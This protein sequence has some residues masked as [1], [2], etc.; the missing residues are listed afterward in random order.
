MLTLAQHRKRFAVLES[1]ASSWVQHWREIALAVRPRGARF[2]S[3]DAQNAGQ[4][5]HSH[6]VNNTPIISS[7]TLAGGLHSGITSAARP[8][9]RIAV[10]DPMLNAAA[11]V[12]HWLDEVEQEIRDALERSNFYNCLHTGYC[13]LSDFG[14]TCLIE[15]EDE[16]DSVRFY[17]A[18]IGSYFL[19]QSHRLAA[20]TL[21]R[22][23]NLTVLQ[24]VNKFCRAPSGEV[25]TSPLTASTRT[26]WESKR[27]DDV[28]EC[29]HVIAPAEDA[30]EQRASQGRP[31]LSWW[32]E[33]Q[34]SKEWT[35]TATEDGKFLRQSG[36]EERPHFMPRWET[37]GEDVYGTS[38][39]MVALGDCNALQVLEKRKAQLVELSARPPMAGPAGL[40]N[41]PISLVPGGFTPVPTGDA[42][43]AFRPAFSIDPM[44]IA[45]TA[46]EIRQCEARIR[47]AYYADLWLMLANSEGTMTAREVMERREEKMLQLGT[48]LQKLKDEGLE[49]IITRTFAILL[50]RGRLPEIPRELAGQALKIEFLSIMA[51]A[52]KLQGVTGVERTTVFVQTLSQLNPQ[53]LDKLNVDA[54]VEAYGE[55]TGIPSKLI[56]SDDEVAE[57][58]SS[59]AKAQAQQVAQ[60]QAQQQ[61]DTAKTLAD[62]DTS[63]TNALTEMMRGLGVR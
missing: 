53:A 33:A 58:R 40:R 3:S 19:A 43:N 13:D 30:E 12:R 59:R 29:V 48:V 10:P 23:V 60:A 8:W 9:F 20:D 38:P 11:G 1:E 52:Q 44:A 27:F 7:R 5:K 18:P 26:K 61:A 57:I 24:L 31:W 35:Q 62:T 32:F 28:V 49:P 41:T 42:S 56:R 54:A 16:E 34:G 36:Y 46:E 39:G 17:H 21:Y 47:S 37:T 2:A 4:K 45:R 15:E 51:Q 63:G 22:R 14:T 55:M 6:L 50:R 25:D